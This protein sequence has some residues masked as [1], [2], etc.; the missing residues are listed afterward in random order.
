MTVSS[1]HPVVAAIEHSSMAGPTARAAAEEAVRRRT[2][3]RLV[4]V[5]RKVRPGLLTP[6]RLVGE[7]Q[8]LSR[9]AADE[10]LARTAA[11]VAD[12]LPA[13]R[14]SPHVPIGD[15]AELLVEESVTAGLLVLGGRPGDSLGGPGS[16]TARVVAH[17]AC[18][19]L[20]LPDEDSRA[21]GNGRAV[22]VGIAGD[23]LDELVVQAAFEEADARG[24]ELVAVHAWTDPAMEP[25]FEAW[26]PL[27]D[28]VEVRGEEERLL[29]E[30]LAGW[31]EKFPA[32]EVH[33]AV[34]RDRRGSALRGAAAT[35]ALLVLGH[36][37]RGRIAGLGSTTR[38]VLHHAPCP[39]LV[40][41]LPGERRQP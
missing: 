31:R 5:D 20:A 28:W 22:V 4:H 26:G 9:R 40:V 8:Q 25:S 37:H 14:V 10:L 27:M 33:T 35:A 41:P 23:R 6:A 21:L 13:D 18:P 1:T 11:E 34:V 16:V 30:A 38:A 36:R 24:V 7:P 32:V 3:L 2:G 19:V 39:V 12:L 17:A 29:A 15:A